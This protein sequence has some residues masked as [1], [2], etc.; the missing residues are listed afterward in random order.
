MAVQSGKL[1]Q[2]LRN[3]PGVPV[4]HFNERGVMVMEMP[5]DATLKQ[6]DTVSLHL[7]VDELRAEI[8]AFAS[9]RMRN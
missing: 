6:K 2:H 8:R 4:I 7:S 9:S 5:S 1:R 3:I